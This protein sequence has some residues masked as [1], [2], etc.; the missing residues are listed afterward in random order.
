RQVLYQPSDGTRETFHVSPELV[1]ADSPPAAEAALPARQGPATPAER[2]CRRAETGC[3]RPAASR[4]IDRS[5]PRNRARGDRRR[6][7]RLR[8]RV[9][10]RG[11]LD[12]QA[13]RRALY[14]SEEGGLRID[15]EES[16]SGN[17]DEGSGAAQTCARTIRPCFEDRLLR[18]RQ[19][20]PRRV[21][22]RERLR[23]AGGLLESATGRTRRQ[24]VGHPTGRSHPPNRVGMGP[25]PGRGSR[26]PPPVPCA[27]GGAG[28]RGAS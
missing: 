28:K 3:V 19:P 4:R 24:D 14:D 11:G 18:G 8:V 2:R 21:A 10:V 20:T 7:Q 9:E 22:D 17:G 1:P 27:R 26:G 13:A 5:P 6:R 16:S 12:R 15:R 25:S 23:A